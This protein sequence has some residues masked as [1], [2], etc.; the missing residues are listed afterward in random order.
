MGYHKGSDPPIFA[1]LEEC[2]KED[3]WGDTCKIWIWGQDNS[4]D[5]GEDL[6]TMIKIPYQIP[7]NLEEVV[8]DAVVA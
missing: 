6:L 5:A 7:T 4:L 8:K 1:T 3:P 2:I